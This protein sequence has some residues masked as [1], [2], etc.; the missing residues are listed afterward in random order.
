MLARQRTGQL[1]CP[2]ASLPTL[3]HPV[4]QFFH[5]FRPENPEGLPGF[6]L[7][8]VVGLADQ[9]DARMGE[10]SGRVRGGGAQT[11]LDRSC[12]DAW[13]LTTDIAAYRC[14]ICLPSSPATQSPMKIHF[15][16]S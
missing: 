12:G 16:I 11:G 4:P 1:A 15:L 14:A 3:A 5:L 13:E 7:A 2:A 6:G 9:P 10:V 8:Q